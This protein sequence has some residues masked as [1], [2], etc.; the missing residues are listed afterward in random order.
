MVAGDTV[1]VFDAGTVDDALDDT[2]PD[3]IMHYNPERAASG[4]GDEVLRLSIGLETVDDIIADLGQALD[5]A[6]AKAAE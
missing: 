2:G 1:G 6:Q 4:A 5:Y 3:N